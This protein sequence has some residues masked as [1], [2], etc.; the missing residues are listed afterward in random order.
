[1]S[2][3]FSVTNDDFYAKLSFM[4]HNYAGDAKFIVLDDV[5]GNMLQI[6]SKL[7]TRHPLHEKC[8]CLMT[9]S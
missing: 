8:L 7:A 3:G 9:A 2:I 1:M 6:S 5:L 4:W